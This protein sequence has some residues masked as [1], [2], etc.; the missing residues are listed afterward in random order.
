MGEKSPTRRQFTVGLLTASGIAL[1]GCLGDDDDGDGGDDGD[2][3][4]DDFEALLE[5]PSI[6]IILEN[7]DGERIDGGV[8]VDVDHEIISH[9]VASDDEM[10]DGRVVIEPV[11]HSGTYSIT[12]S[13]PDD[14]FDPVEDEVEFDDDEIED[15]EDKEVTLVLEGATPPEDE[16]DE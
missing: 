14:E 12:V 11:R 1:A 13:S 5:D 3:G 2:D 15:D 4:V 7:E 8:V 10:E 9:Q 6:V 16:A